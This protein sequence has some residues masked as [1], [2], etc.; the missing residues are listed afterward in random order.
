MHACAAVGTR[1]RRYQAVPIALFLIGAF[2]FAPRASRAD[3]YRYVDSQG[4]THYSNASRGAGWTR[5]YKDTSDTTVGDT[6]AYETSSAEGGG[7]DDGDGC[8]PAVLLRRW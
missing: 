6:T 3:I 4:V 2:A 8:V 5:V 1:S 7:G